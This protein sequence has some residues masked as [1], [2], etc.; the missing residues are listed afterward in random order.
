[1]TDLIHVKTDMTAYPTLC[2][3]DPGKEPLSWTTV[4]SARTMATCAEC[5]QDVLR[6]EC[7]CIGGTISSGG[8][9]E[10]GCCTR[11]PCPRCDLDAAEAII[12]A[13]K[14]AK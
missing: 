9:D 12:E 7:D 14:V 10:E 5:L 2:G 8:C 11:P 3:F 13:R 4:Y 6:D 1:M